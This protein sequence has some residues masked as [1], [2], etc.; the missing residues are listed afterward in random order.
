M[1]WFEDNLGA[2]G[3]WLDDSI[4][5]L[6]DGLE[7]ALTGRRDGRTL[8]DRVALVLE[9]WNQAAPRTR[10][11]IALS[12]FGLALL[13]FAVVSSTL[14]STPPAP[15]LTAAEEQAFL[16]A[17]AVMQQQGQRLRQRATTGASPQLVPGRAG[18][19]GSNPGVA[20]SR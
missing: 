12:M 2:L 9:R 15:P 7:R 1:G 20:G 13:T 8:A 3:R 11:I 18:A 14:V 4:V 6:R 5:W 17:Q 10:R 19:A 16:R